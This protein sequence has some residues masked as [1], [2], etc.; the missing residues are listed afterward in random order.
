MN[1]VYT[2]GRDEACDI[3]I[4]DHTDVVSRLHATLRYEG[5]GKYVL[6]DQSLNGTYVNGIKMTANEEIP[7]TRKD[8]I[9]FAH[10]QELDWSRVPKPGLSGVAK[11]LIAVVVV[12]L[13]A[14]GCYWGWKYYKGKT[15]DPQSVTEVPADTA[16]VQT[17]DTVEVRDT[18]YIK[19]KPVPKEEQKPEIKNVEEQPPQEEEKVVNPLY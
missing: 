10:V 1:K 12:L 3:V 16:I 5:K 9:S 7:V 17:P 2:I 15:S 4:N 19:P 18:V 14:A 11:G 13:L 8:V 6:V